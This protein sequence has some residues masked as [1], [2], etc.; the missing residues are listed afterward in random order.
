[1]KYND[2]MGFGLVDAY[3]AVQLAETWTMSSTAINEISDS[4]RAFNLN[5]AIPDGDGTSYTKTFKIDNAIQVEHIELG[6]DLRH[7]RLGDLI[8]EVIS[9]D[10]TVTRLMD[11][12]TV[13]AEQPFGLSGA[14]S[15]VPNHL[16]WDFSSVQFM[17][18]QAI[19]EWTVVVKDVRA[20]QVGTINS[21]SLRVYGQRADGNDTYVFTEE[22]FKQQ[23][24]S[25]LQDES[26]TDTINA[27]VMLHDVNIDL[28]L[29]VIASQGVTYSI[30]DWTL[31][32][33]AFTGAGND[34][35]VG[36]A[37]NNWLQGRAGDDV[38]AGGLGNDTLD[39]GL[40]SDTVTY[41]GARAEYNVSYNP[42]TKKITVIDNKVT[43]GDDGT[44]TLIGIERI[45]FSDVLECNSRQ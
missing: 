30:A 9:P 25:V 21:L 1:M 16:L 42:T 6:I 40:G 39:G 32:E 38:L 7:A 33:Q 36:N 29:G 26:G 11:R 35:L 27:S 5:A 24:T 18:E 3:A 28:S 12:P 43:G 37:A 15:G 22:G 31:I 41:A 44:D 45:V 34:R 17:G 23:S 19:G 14:D 8:V 20:E 2:G 10:G 4:A 13:N